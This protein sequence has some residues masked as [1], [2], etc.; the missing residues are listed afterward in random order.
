MHRQLIPLTLFS[1]WLLAS[2][3]ANDKLVIKMDLLEQQLSDQRSLSKRMER[4]LDDMQIQVTL[5]ARKLDSRRTSAQ[6]EAGA[7]AASAPDLKVVRLSPPAIDLRQDGSRPDRPE[8]RRPPVRRKAWKLTEAKLDDVDPAE[9]TERLPVDRA[10][11]KR[12][13]AFHAPSS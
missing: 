13:P 8:K 2:G 10:A 4:R 7:K 6:P 3:C 5:L 1:T 11:A 9:V 12:S